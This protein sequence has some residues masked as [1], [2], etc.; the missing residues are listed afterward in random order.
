MLW[1]REVS[2]TPSTLSLN[3]R[4]SLREPAAGPSAPGILRSL[5]A[6][7]KAR[8]DAPD[9]T[10]GPETSPGPESGERDSQLPPSLRR[11]AAPLAAVVVG[12]FAEALYRQGG[13]FPVDA[14][15]LAVVSVILIALALVWFEDRAVVPVT[16]AVGGLAVWWFVRAVLERRPGAF[17]PVGASILGFLAAF[18]VIKA[19]GPPDRRR[20]A[21]AVVALGALA[22]ATGIVGVLFH[23]HAWAYESGGYWQPASL[24]TSPAAVAG[25]AVIALLAAM[26]LDLRSRLVRLA[27]FA[28]LV[29][30]IGTRDHWALFALVLGAACVPL[31]RWAAATVTLVL[32]VAAGGVLVAA[33][34]GRLAPWLATV[35]VV[36]LAGGAALA[37]DRR[38][39]TTG[40]VGGTTWLLLGVVVLGTAW[41]VI[42]PPVASGPA[43]PAN[44]AQTLAWSSAA[45]AWRSST[46]DGIGPRA[47]TASRE[48]VDTFPGITPDTYLGITA[49]AG[50]LGLL[51]LVGAGAAVGLS[52]ARR[53]ALSS[54]AAGGVVAFAVIGVV[55]S[56]WQMPALAVMGGCVAALASAPAGEPREDASV[57]EPGGTRG[58]S[59]LGRAR[60]AAVCAGVVVVLVTAQMAVGFA[61]DAGGGL[62]NS[63]VAAPPPSATPAAPARIILTGPDPTDPYM[64]KTQGRYYLY[65]SE[66]TSFLNVPVWVGSRPGQWT[67]PVDALP[68][69]PDWAG[70]GETWAPDV[71]QVAGGWALY[72]T[73]LLRG[74]NPDT[75]CIGSAFASS[76]T[77]PFV[78]SQR[79]FICQ[80]DHRGSIDARVIDDGGHLVML[81]KSEDN[82]NPY[83]PGPD[84][85]GMTGIY[86]Q[87]LSADGQRLLGQPVKIFGP[88]QPWERTIVEA[89]DMVEAWGTYWLFF[90]GNWYYSTS[91]GIGVAACQTPF[92]PCS[93]LSPKP[94]IGSNLQG[95]G[96]GEESI[97]QDGSNV[98]LLYNPFKANDP[99]PDV[100]RPVAMTRL[101]FTPQ[102]PYLASP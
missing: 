79:T 100:P 32:G 1:R 52:T 49:D 15:G 60:Q 76:P 80:L 34:A 54:C 70:G 56:D 65:A 3:A 12:M 26:G 81:W 14:F 41:L 11:S 89:P 24:L 36:L 6:P 74:V 23:S 91:Y 51:L 35:L 47:V 83:V 38:P 21:A 33:A 19:L 59:G 7:E 72:F 64:L 8:P 44:Q 28:C 37:A 88:S 98:Y 95:A 5:A 20:V 68:H 99:G 92:G 53:D 10:V 48:P 2:W 4:M 31:R 82:A 84:Q 39:Q 77:G 86:A 94:F 62:A 93:D 63:G 30:L 97:F 87:N 66:G 75:H 42:R 71:Y 16:L 78:A 58:R 13:F 102:G 9:A 29:A 43:Q 67:G 96:A 101:G 18:V 17:L 69:L 50:L 22:A 40:A 25:V 85:N 90:S 73:A 57:A 46:V 61:R 45:H 55:T 27:L